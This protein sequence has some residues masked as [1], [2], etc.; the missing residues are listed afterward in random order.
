MRLNIS[1]IAYGISGLTRR[2]SRQQI[3]PSCGSKFFTKVDKKGFHELLRCDNCGLS[4]RFPYETKEECSFFYQTQY[5]QAGLTTD[6]PDEETLRNL[7]RSKFKNTEKDFSRI[8]ELFK[9]LPL[10][11]NA[12]ILDFGANWGYGVWQLNQAGYSAMGFE[13]SQPR[14]EFSKKLNVHVLTDWQD[15]VAQG[16]FDLV[17]SSH[18]LEHTPDPAEALHRQISI[19]VPGG[20]LVA[21]FPNG[22]LT[23][24]KKSPITFHKLWG[25]VHPVMLNEAFLRNVFPDKPLAVGAISHPDII[26]I[27]D[28][29]NRI[30]WTGDLSRSEMLAV[31]I[32]ST[33]A[34]DDCNRAK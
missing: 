10:K 19:L 30:S 11:D 23:F 26:S 17:F 6:L 15:V 1:K 22:S 16:P 34:N 14:A 33:S 13:L 27:A 31:V 5:Q 7:L 8:V 4:Y 24:H 2:F 28:W 12:R 25:Q 3:C 29:D 20:I 21:V 9:A 18:V 32:N